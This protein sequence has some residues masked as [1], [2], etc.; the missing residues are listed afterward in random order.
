[1]KG[2]LVFKTI[3]RFLLSQVFDRKYPLSIGIQITNRCNLRCIYCNYPGNKD[4]GE[5]D[6]DAWIRIIEDMSNS[7]VRAVSI[8]GGEPMVKE[9]IID[10]INFCKK[11]GLFVLLSTNGFR[12]KDSVRGLASVDNLSVS[13]DGEE[14]VH[15]SLR[16]KGSYKTALEAI[17]ASKKQG[18]NTTHGTVLS[19]VNVGQVDYILK[20]AA[21]NGTYCYFQVL[22]FNPEGSTVSKNWKTESGINRINLDTNEVKRVFAYLAR[23]KKEGAPIASSHRYLDSVAKWPYYPSFHAR[24]RFGNIRCFAGKHYCFVYPDGAMFAYNSLRNAQVF[25]LSVVAVGNNSHKK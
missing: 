3:P 9:N 6:S 8:S 14:S 7:G 5:L 15:D 4:E 24:D 10:I 13:L 11:K 18:I 25:D 16:G 2:S 21:E 23:R 12:V 22:E 19:K 17:R 20:F 1:M